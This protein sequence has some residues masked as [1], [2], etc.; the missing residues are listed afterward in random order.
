MSDS[1]SDSVKTDIGE[2]FGLPSMK[3]RF[4]GVLPDDPATAA[5]VP[6]VRSYIFR[7]DLLEFVMAS[8]AL[9]QIKGRQCPIWLVGEPGTGK[10]SMFEQLYARLNQPFISITVNRRTEV[11]DLIHQK[12]I[13]GGDLVTEDGP[14]V[15]AMRNGWPFV[16]NEITLLNP[17]TSTGLNEIVEAGQ[18]T[19]AATGERITAKTGFAVHATDNTRGSGDGE[20]VGTNRI[21]PALIDRFAMVEVNH[22]TE[23][24]ETQKIVAACDGIDEVVVR[25]YISVATLT[26]KAAADGSLTTP[27]TPRSLMR[28]AEFTGVF[29]QRP[30]ALE[31]ALNAAYLSRLD[32]HEREAVMD[33]V[34]IAWSSTTT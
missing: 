20:Y 28:W 9:S 19:I 27:M 31:F 29:Q 18:V 15:T 13:L 24:E 23:D 32:P 5:F 34:S 22:M 4:I 30:D 8:W 2:L 17:A 7:H 11:D 12:V 6:Q 3:G 21:N 25:K 16:I 33:M 10:T 26:R 14:L 1:K